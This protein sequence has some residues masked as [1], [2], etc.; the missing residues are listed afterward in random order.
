MTPFELIAMKQ[1]VGREYADEAELFVMIHFDACKR[2]ALGPIGYNF[3]SR[4][5]VMA[6]FI[7]AKLRAADRMALVLKASEAWRKVGGRPGDLAS[8]TTG[9]Y[10]AIRAGLNSY[11]QA[12]PRIEAGTYRQACNVADQVMR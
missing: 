2:E 6:Q 4:H 11:F 12:L 1:K 5:L 8:M 10:L 7:F 9:E 3:I